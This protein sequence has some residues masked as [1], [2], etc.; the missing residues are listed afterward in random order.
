MSRPTGSRQRG[1][2]REASGRRRGCQGAV[3]R[4]L[5]CYVDPV[6]WRRPLAPSE[7]SGSRSLGRISAKSVRRQRLAVAPFASALTGSPVSQPK[8]G[9]LGATRSGPGLSP[10]Q[11]D[12]GERKVAEAPA[13]RERAPERNR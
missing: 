6:G 12:W 10:G 4:L 7:S 3:S 8:S 2:P 5:P 1:D 11:A 13:G 9:P